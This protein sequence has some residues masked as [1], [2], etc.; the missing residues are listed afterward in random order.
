MH[1]QNRFNTRLTMVFSVLFL[2]SLVLNIY[3]YLN[4]DPAPV[5]QAGTE[6]QPEQPASVSDTVREADTT[7]G[8]DAPDTLPETVDEAGPEGPGEAPPVSA[9]EPGR[10][11]APETPPAGS[12]SSPAE[13]SEERPAAP[14]TPPGQPTTPDT[15]EQDT[16]E[17]DT[18]GQ[19]TGEIMHVVQEEEHL[20]GIAVLYFNDGYQY[21]EL[22]RLNG[23][24]S[25]DDIYT[26]QEL[27][28]KE[29]DNE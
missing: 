3:L 18:T 13:Q 25:P 16:T 26:G 29:A 7:T 15:T 5:D 17:R 21:H 14:A 27:I 23:L 28:I 6:M 12:P 8:A 9:G 11:Q 4:S 20:W 1:R 2:A 10:K 19:S 24:E 22:M